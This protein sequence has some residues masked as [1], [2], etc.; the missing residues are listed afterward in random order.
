[1]SA[2][3]VAQLQSLPDSALT[4]ST[5]VENQVAP[6]KSRLHAPALPNGNE[7]A[8]CSLHAN[9]HQYLQVD[10]GA[11]KVIVQVATQ[12][13]DRSGNPNWV[14]SYK[15]ST[16]LNGGGFEYLMNEYGSEKVSLVA[17]RI[18]SIS[19]QVNK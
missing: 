7:G 15:L 12:G 4:A 10:L 14:T 5:F 9:A 13:K 18:H 8:W 11:V 2:N 6:S 19:P 3:R 16:F 17:C 1:M